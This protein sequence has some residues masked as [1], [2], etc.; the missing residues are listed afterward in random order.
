MIE[1]QLLVGLDYN[2]HQIF[3]AISHLVST[4]TFVSLGII[5]IMDFTDIS[6]ILIQYFYCMPP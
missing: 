1:P 5:H 3:L 4:G 2:F 6:E